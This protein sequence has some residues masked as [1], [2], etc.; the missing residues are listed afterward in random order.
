MNVGSAGFSTGQALYTCIAFDQSSR[1]YVAYVD[2]GNSSK[3]TIMSFD[4][5]NW[6]AV[7]GMAFSAGKADYTR[8]AFSQNTGEPYVV[9]ED[10]GSSHKAW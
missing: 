1:P 7:G 5:L 3:A 2:E 10:Y 6:T 9:Y 8:L 4:A